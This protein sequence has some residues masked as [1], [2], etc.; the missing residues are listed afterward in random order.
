MRVRTVIG[1]GVFTDKFVIPT[2]GHLNRNDEVV[3]VVT[4]IFV[5]KQKVV[6][7]DGEQKLEN[8]GF[9]LVPVLKYEEDNVVK[10]RK[11][12]HDYVDFV[13][14]NLDN[15]LKQEVK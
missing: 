2:F 10:L 6:T 4:Q 7:E 3:D 13:C 1:C 12:L 11:K 8:D 15:I 9:L 14:D 5:P